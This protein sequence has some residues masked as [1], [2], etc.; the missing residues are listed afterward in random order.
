MLHDF[1]S[2]CK[3]EDVFVFLVLLL[4]LIGTLTIFLTIQ[5]RKVRLAEMEAV[6]KQDMLNRGMSADEIRTVL[7]TPVA[8]ATPTPAHKRVVIGTE[9]ASVVIER[10]RSGR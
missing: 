7:Q 2:R 3:P 8:A 4:L 10:H 1:L 9:G 5:W 6:L